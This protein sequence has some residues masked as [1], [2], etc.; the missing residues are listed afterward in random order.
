MLGILSEDGQ[1]KSV[2]DTFAIE[3]NPDENKVQDDDELGLLGRNP[4]R[5]C[6]HANRSRRDER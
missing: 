3:M 6:D 1:L 2:T 5:H 4:S